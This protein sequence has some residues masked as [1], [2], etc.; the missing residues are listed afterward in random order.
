MEISVY[1]PSSARRW[2][3]GDKQMEIRHSNYRF[4]V[5]RTQRT[6]EVCLLVVKQ[7]LMTSQVLCHATELDKCA[8]GRRR[9]KRTQWWIQRELKHVPVTRW[10]LKTTEYEIQSHIIETFLKA[11]FGHHLLTSLQLTEYSNIYFMYLLR[12]LL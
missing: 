12:N 9:E 1:L 4:G 7:I 8:A 5:L 3:A 11:G 2:I 6:A 10:N